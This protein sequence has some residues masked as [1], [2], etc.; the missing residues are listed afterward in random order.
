MLP[1]TALP[2]AGKT[3]RELVYKQHAMEPALGWLVYIVAP[4]AA[5]V[6]MAIYFARREAKMVEAQQFLRPV[7][8]LTTWL[9]FGLNYAFLQFPWPWA[10]WT[11]RTPNAIIYTLC[12]IGL[13]WLALRGGRRRSR[14]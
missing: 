6:A 2:I 12:A 8:L 1:I 4:T 5:C 13:T 10:Q 9:Y 11:T 7:M 3:L 14:G